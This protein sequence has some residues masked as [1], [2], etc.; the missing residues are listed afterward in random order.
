[1]QRKTGHSA[2][3]RGRTKVG[4]TLTPE[5]PTHSYQQTQQICKNLQAVVGEWE[6]LTKSDRRPNSSLQ[7]SKNMW[8]WQ[9]TFRFSCFQLADANE[10]AFTCINPALT[11]HKSVCRLA[12][13]R[14]SVRTQNEQTLQTGKLSLE[15]STSAWTVWQ[16]QSRVG[17]V[18]WQP[19][20]RC[21][22]YFHAG[23]LILH[24]TLKGKVQFYTKHYPHVLWSKGFTTITT[25]LWNFCLACG[26]W[27]P[28]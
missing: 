4:L 17:A 8:M 3:S 16:P 20:F 13:C 1:M 27:E 2:E 9:A 18:P 26:S 11:T 10:H 15:I 14:G 25:S 22:L 21:F 23:V 6:I 28:N 19:F 7:L 24:R 5:K 12:D